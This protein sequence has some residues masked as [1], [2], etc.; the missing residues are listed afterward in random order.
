MS[1]KFGATADPPPADATAGGVAGDIPFKPVGGS[2][3]GG[4]PP[5]PPDCGKYSLLTQLR[6]ESGIRP[7]IA[8]LISVAAISRSSLHDASEYHAACGVQ[9]RFGA[10][11]RGP[12]E[13]V[14][15]DE[16]REKRGEKTEHERSGRTAG[17]RATPNDDREVVDDDATSTTATIATITTSR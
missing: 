11:L 13:D 9:I 8:R 16:F 14:P 6:S 17:G 5:G 3:I 12:V 10:S 15:V 2:Y 1:S 4:G 7:Q